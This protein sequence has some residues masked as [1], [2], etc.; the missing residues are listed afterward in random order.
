MVDFGA[1]GRRVAPVSPRTFARGVDDQGELAQKATVR[2]I[3]RARGLQQ[4]GGRNLIEPPRPNR[5]ACGV[6][7]TREHGYPKRRGGRR[8]HGRVAI[9]GWRSLLGNKSRRVEESTPGAAVGH[10]VPGVD[11]SVV[12]NHPGRHESPDEGMR[13]NV[14]G[15]QRLRGLGR[16][17]LFRGSK[18]SPDGNAMETPRPSGT[19][20]RY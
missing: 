9:E 1:G 14:G 16:G 11:R 17:G 15:A 18:G 20:C 13:R 12:G 4:V 19:R 3:A 7:P 10:A 2:A 5:V 8:A 6:I